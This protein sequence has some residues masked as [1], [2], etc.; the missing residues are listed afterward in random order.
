MFTT[1]GQGTASH[2][3]DGDGLP[4]TAPPLGLTEAAPPVP[5]GQDSVDAFEDLAAPL[6]PSGS[7]AW[8]AYFSLAPGSPTLAGLNPK[9]PAGS[10]PAAILVYDPGYGTLSVL[11]PIRAIGLVVAD[12]IDGIALDVSRHDFLFSLAPGSPSLLT[13]AGCPCTPGDFIESPSAFCGPAPCLAIPAA[14]AGLAGLDNADAVDTKGQAV[15]FRPFAGKTFSL[16]PKSPTLR[17]IEVILPAG[18]TRPG[19]AADL[20]TLDRRNPTGAPRVIFPAESL[21]LVAG[22]D[23]DGVSFGN[24][25]V[26]TGGDYSVDFSVDRSA[27]GVAGTGVNSEVSAVTGP[28]ASPDVFMSFMPAGAPPWFAGTNAQTWDGNG[29]TAPLLQLVDVAYNVLRNDDLDALEGPPRIADADLDGARDRTV[30][31]SLSVGSPTLAAIGAGPGDILACPPPGCILPTVFMP[32]GAIGLQPDEELEDF[33]L[34]D[35]AGLV[36]FTL[37]PGS[38]TLAMVGADPGSILRNGLMM[39]MVLFLGPASGLVGGIGGDNM[40][41]LDCTAPVV[42]CVAM[43]PAPALDPPIRVHPG[44]C[45]VGTPAGPYDVITGHLAEVANIGPQIDVGHAWCRRDELAEDRL[46]LRTGVDQLD[47]LYVLVRNGAGV[48]ADYG[49]DSGGLMRYPSVGG[50]P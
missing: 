11:F 2:F 45:T 38:P 43:S 32:A 28:E 49:Q 29:S 46:T 27:L 18:T 50:C 15:L 7:P 30:Y 40:N 48:Q 33:C 41:A 16:G 24:E 35:A 12:D 44:P 19:S 1:F 21:G 39:P 36:D 13:I 20:L 42:A 31:F 3:W 47:T 14:N 37:P 17:A 34:H 5:G 26:Y 25:P 4:G 22:D 8:R 6:L 23:I 10:D 9:L